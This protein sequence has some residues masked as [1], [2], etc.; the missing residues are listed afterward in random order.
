MIAERLRTVGVESI[1]FRNQ[2]FGLK[3]TP[4]EA[5]AQFVRHFLESGMTFDE[6]CEVLHNM[7]TNNYRLKLK[8]EPKE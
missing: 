5:D 4:E 1:L 2:I 6:A 3:T 7:V 8:H